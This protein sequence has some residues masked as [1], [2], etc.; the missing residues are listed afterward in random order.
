[1]TYLYVL[2]M[3]TNTKQQLCIKPTGFLVVFFLI[4]TQF[5]NWSTLG[6][7]DCSLYLRTSTEKLCM[8]KRYIDKSK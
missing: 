1:M 8:Y 7:I 2:S 3:P 5:S 6:I 4:D